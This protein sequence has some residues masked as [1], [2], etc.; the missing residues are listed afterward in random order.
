VKTDTALS[1]KGF[2]LSASLHGAVFA[3]AG[4]VL[5]QPAQVG[6][7]ESTVTAEFQVLS[8]VAPTLSM[9]PAEPSVADFKATPENHDEMPVTDGDEETPQE[10]IPQEIPVETGVPLPVAKELPVAEAIPAG[11][12]PVVPPPSPSRTT[13]RS[14][15]HPAAVANCGARSILPDYLNNPAPRY[16]ESSRLAGEKGVV[17]VR[18]GIGTTGEVSRVELARSSGY[19]ELDHAA[20]EAVKGWKFRPASAAGIA[21]ASEVTVPVRFELHQGNSG[22]IRNP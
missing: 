11:S 6:T 3:A 10:V 9:A 19:P 14:V 22:T 17:L 16:P 12:L 18:A 4:L 5:L 2:A 7:Q 20:V 13:R 21:M 1:W 15:P 8:D